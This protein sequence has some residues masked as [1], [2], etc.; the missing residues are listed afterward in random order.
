MAILIIY[1]IFGLTHLFIFNFQNAGLVEYH[2]E[3]Y[4][5]KNVNSKGQR[6]NRMTICVHVIE[7]SINILVVPVI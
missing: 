5:H 2:I 1:F 6:Q 4:K 7:N 3:V